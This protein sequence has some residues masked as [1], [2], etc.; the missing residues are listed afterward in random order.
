MKKNYLFAIFAILLFSN[1]EKTVKDNIYDK[2]STSDED[3]NLVKTYYKAQINEYYDNVVL[4]HRSS[5]EAQGLRSFLIPSFDKA[6]TS[7]LFNGSSSIT[8]PAD[9]SID[10]EEIGFYRSFVF[11]KAFGK[12]MNAKIVEIIGKDPDF[13]EK[14]KDD[15]LEKYNNPTIEG[16]TG[17][18]LTYDLYYRPLRNRT[19]ENGKVT[20][21]ASSLVKT[22]G[23]GAKSNSIQSTGCEQ[24]ASLSPNFKVMTASIVPIFTSSSANSS[25]CYDVYWV[26]SSGGSENWDYLYSYCDDCGGGAGGGGS[27][28]PTVPI[29]SFDSFPPNPYNGQVYVLITASGERTEFTFNSDLGLWL[30]PEVQVFSD[31]GYSLSINGA[32]SFDSNHILTAIAL[33]AL[34]VPSFAG[35]LIVAGT[36]VVL[37]GIYVYEFAK[38]TAN[39]GTFD[40]ELH[41]YCLS[42]Y[43]PCTNT[44]HETGY[45]CSTCLQFCEAQ[46]YWSNQC[47]YII[48]ESQSY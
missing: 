28:N 7:V 34:V 8:V 6:Q 46:G 11:L 42:Y 41:L 24:S 27:S 36:A 15:I 30:L 48:P 29:S 25:Q 39:K 16:F 31:L 23:G 13:V 26:T 2:N 21:A 18:I 45:D 20:N 43:V 32:P 38:W 1:C 9:F 19:Y 33:P 10:N 5:S 17:A 37:T 35:Q 3:K 22:S 47:P 14:N 4:N 40:E 12:I 44:V